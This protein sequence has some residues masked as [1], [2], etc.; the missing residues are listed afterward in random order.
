MFNNIVQILSKIM[1][2]DRVSIENHFD[3]DY[4]IINKIIPYAWDLVQTF[5][6][7]IE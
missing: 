7:I 3:L 1:S 6:P 5:K 4:S 2:I